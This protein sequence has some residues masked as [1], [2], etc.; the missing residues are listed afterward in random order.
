M[1]PLNHHIF[2]TIAFYV[3]SNCVLFDSYCP[4]MNKYIYNFSSFRN[5]LNSFYCFLK[6]ALLTNS[7][8]EHIFFHTV[9]VLYFFMGLFYR[10]CLRVFFGCCFFRW[11]VRSYVFTEKIICWIWTCNSFGFWKIQCSFFQRHLFF[12]RNSSSNLLLIR[13]MKTPEIY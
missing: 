7:I 12:S 5:I 6:E 8:P 1:F 2:W 4:F 10:R 13:N 3:V 11:I 9:T